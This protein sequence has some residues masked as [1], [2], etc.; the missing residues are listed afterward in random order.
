M[1]DEEPDDREQEEL[2]RQPV[3][4]TVDRAA[5]ATCEAASHDAR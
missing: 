3:E 4:R 1:P 2:A 5:R